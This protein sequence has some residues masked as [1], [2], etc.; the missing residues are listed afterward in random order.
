M[1]TEIELLWARA[2]R[3]LVAFLRVEVELGFT[4]AKLASIE[5]QLQEREGVER[6]SQIAYSTVETVR[7]FEHRIMDSEIQ[8]ELNER[9]HEL[10]NVLSSLS[11]VPNT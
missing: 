3:N 5:V 4:F 9:A 2:D 8:R 11:C 1:D 6:A 10:Q 7:R